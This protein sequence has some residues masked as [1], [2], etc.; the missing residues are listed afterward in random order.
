[1][2]E[3]RGK[4]KREFNAFRVGDTYVFKHHFGPDIFEELRPYYDDEEYRFAVP[5]VDMPEVERLLAANFY[6]VALVEDAEEYCVAR[7]KD[8]DQPRHLFEKSVLR[9]STRYHHVYLL[10]DLA[11]VEEAVYHGAVPLAEVEVEEVF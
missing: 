8:E 2:T 7:A 5:Q 9:K 1:M 6:D 4:R 3:P 11:A 10:V